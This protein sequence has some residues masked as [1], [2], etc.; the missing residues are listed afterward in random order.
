[1]IIPR[2]PSPEPA[3]KGIA[4]LSQEEINRLAEERLAEIKVLDR[5]DIPFTCPGEPLTFRPAREETRDQAGLRRD[6]RP[7]RRG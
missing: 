2:T 3:P 6:V 7:H 4:G 5:P 1:M